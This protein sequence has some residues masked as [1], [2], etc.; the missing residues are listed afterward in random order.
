MDAPPRTTTQVVD[1]RESSPDMG[2]TRRVWTSPGWTCPDHPKQECSIRIL[3][4]SRTRLGLDD[5]S[6]LH[7]EIHVFEQADIGER[8]AVHGDHVGVQP[9]PDRTDLIAAAKQFPA[10]GPGRMRAWNSPDGQRTRQPTPGCPGRSEGLRPRMAIRARD[11]HNR[12]NANGRGGRWARS[13]K[14]RFRTSATTPT[15]R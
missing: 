1:S 5:L 9:G 15:C 3:S 4:W 2:R 13:T 10:K 11:S 6:T 14:R 7:H 8:I 12:R